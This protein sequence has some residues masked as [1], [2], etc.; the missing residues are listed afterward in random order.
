MVN[1]SWIN[2]YKYYVAILLNMMMWRYDAN[3]MMLRYMTMLRCYYGNV[4]MLL[5]RCYDAIM[6][7]LRYSKYGDAT[8]YGDIAMLLSLSYH[9]TKT[10]LW[11]YT[12]LRLYYDDVTM[13]LCR[14]YD[15]TQAMVHF[16][17]DNITILL[18]QRSSCCRSQWDNV[19]FPD[20]VHIYSN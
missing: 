7:T 19:F 8:V 10:M 17:Y 18:S 14:C 16:Y 5:W 4:T 3:I 12:M 15:V 6:A 20:I 13:L 11:R 2:I 9:A 1:A